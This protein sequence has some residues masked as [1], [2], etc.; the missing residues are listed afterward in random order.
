[1]TAGAV[2]V[3]AAQRRGRGLS[4]D[5]GVKTGA[6]DA[7]DGDLASL[8]RRGVVARLVLDEL[9]CFAK[10]RKGGGGEADKTSL[11]HYR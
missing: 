7:A 6:V 8:E 9:F 5:G 3:V 1:M 2:V 10:R 4:G 11:P